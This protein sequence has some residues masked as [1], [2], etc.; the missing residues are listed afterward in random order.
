MKTKI[1]SYNILNGFTPDDKPY[2]LNQERKN[3]AIKALEKEKPDVLILCEG[4]FWPSAKKDTLKDFKKLFNNL[5]N[6]FLPAENMFRWAPVIFSKFPIKFSDFSEYHRKYIRSEI[7]V[8]KK[9]II[10][11]VYHPSPDK[12]TEEDRVDFLAKVLEKNLGNHIIAGDFNAI[13]PED[14]YDRSQLLRGFSKFMGPSAEAKVN[15]LMKAKTVKFVLDK[16]FVDT[17]KIKEQKEKY[18]VPTDFRSKNKDAAI[19]IDYIFCSKDIMIIDAGIIKN[20][21]TE[22]ASDHYPIYAVL[23]I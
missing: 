18:T 13:S 1:V 23:K 2:T 9:K 7:S 3:A 4:Y 12:I 20:K 22:I 16:G 10:L 21:F 14:E 6:V 17:Y 15:E 19:R 11:D 8:G 5:T